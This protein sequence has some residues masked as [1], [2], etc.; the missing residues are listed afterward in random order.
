MSRFL[1]RTGRSSSNFRAF[2]WIPNRQA[3]SQ[4]LLQMEKSF[5]VVQISPKIGLHVWI[6]AGAVEFHFTLDS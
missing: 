5:Q 3:G 6:T 2:L 1:L 4:L